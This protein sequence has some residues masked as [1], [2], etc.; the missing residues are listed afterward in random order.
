MGKLLG[1]C[2]ELL[3]PVPGVEHVLAISTNPFDLFGSGP[4]VLVRL[5]PAEQRKTAREKV[6]ESIRARLEAFEEATVRIRDLSQP[7]RTPDFRYPI[8]FALHGLE[9]T[10]VRDWA[11]E[12]GERLARSKKLTDIWVNRDAAA[13]PHRTVDIDRDAAAVRGVSLP[14]VMNT[15]RIFFGAQHVGD[16]NRF[17]R[18]WRVEVQ[19]DTGRRDWADGLRELKIRNSRGQMIP[20]N[21]F[22]T[23]RESTQP[24][25][26]HF[27]DYQPMVEVTANPAAGVSVEQAR[28]LCEAAAHAA[29]RDL[30]LGERYRLTW[31]QDK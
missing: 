8:D 14:E 3:R 1:R 9:A 31:L 11:R 2:D 29:R 22:V 7:G 4:C 12:L 13:R 17:G 23:L 30:G 20:L 5:T 6:I 21:A 25:A 10:R 27:L 18:T 26:L 24:L 19:A 15:L 28:K 16:F